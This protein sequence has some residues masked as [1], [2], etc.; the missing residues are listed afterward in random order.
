MLS[1]TGHN[2]LVSNENFS[3]DTHFRR[4]YRN[5]AVIKFDAPSTTAA[6][7]GIK[8]KMES[9]TPAEKCMGEAATKLSC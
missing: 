6:R 9:K 4:V 3:V 7:N 1:D 8:D 5:N 2:D